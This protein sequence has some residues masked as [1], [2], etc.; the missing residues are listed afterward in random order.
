MCALS[1]WTTF[2][3]EI[4]IQTSRIARLL[5]IHYFKMCYVQQRVK[6]VGYREGDFRF[7]LFHVVIGLEHG[8]VNL[9]DKLVQGVK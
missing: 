1:L 8:F 6:C 7:S 5:H 4:I 3:N 2:E 9:G